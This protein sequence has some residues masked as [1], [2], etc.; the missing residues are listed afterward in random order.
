MTNLPQIVSEDEWLAARRDLLRR[1]KEL[2]A[3]RDELN[4][5]RRR[6]PMVRVDKDY[7]FEGPDGPVHLRDLFAGASQLIVKHFMFDPS[8]SDGCPGCSADVDELA[9]GLVEHLRSRDTSYA[10]ISRAPFTTMEDYRARRGWDIVWYSSFGSDFNYDFHASL[11]GQVR[12]VRY[13]FRDLDELRAK[14]ETWEDDEKQEVPGVSCF[15]RI[16]DE[17]FHTYSTFA[18]GTE[19]LGGSY[20]M[21]DLTSFGRSEKWEEPKGRVAHP[22]EADPGFTD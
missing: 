12:P 18:R 15:L 13:N 2:T 20:S 3:Q 22:H 17:I 11:D 14:G 21:L 10:V 5:D 6:L 7:V 9:P 8:W 1:E 19:Y 16:G 4:A